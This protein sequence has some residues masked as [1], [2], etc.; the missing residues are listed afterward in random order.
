M[1]ALTCV[2]QTGL[3]A[4]G[5]RDKTLRIWRIQ[6]S[7]MSWTCEKARS[8]SAATTAAFQRTANGLWRQMAAGGQKGWAS[9]PDGRLRCDRQ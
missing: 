9:T 1:T 6:T 4:S 5:S 2:G 3:I 8:A 7:D